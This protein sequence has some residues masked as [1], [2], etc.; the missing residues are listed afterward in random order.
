[1][2]SLY[3]HRLVWGPALVWT[4][5]VRKAWLVREAWL[6]RGAA[7]LVREASGSLGAV[8]VAGVQ[9]HWLLLLGRPP[10]QRHSL[11]LRQR[12]WLL[13]LGLPLA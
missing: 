12:H 2:T 11:L 3:R 5:L 7:W 4:W 9:R 6:V 13:L 1:M 10:L 8:L